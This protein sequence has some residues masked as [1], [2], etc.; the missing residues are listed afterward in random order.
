MKVRNGFVSNSSSSSFIISLEEKDKITHL[1]LDDHMMEW[2]KEAADDQKGYAY[3]DWN[4]NRVEDIKNF[5]YQKTLDEYIEKYKDQFNQFKKDSIDGYEEINKYQVLDN[6]KYN[7]DDLKW[8]IEYKIKGNQ[9]M[10]ARDYFDLYE[11][12]NYF[13]NISKFFSNRIRAQVQKMLK[14]RSKKNLYSCLFRHDFEPYTKLYRGRLFGRDNGDKNKMANRHRRYNK[15]LKENNKK[16]DKI[17]NYSNHKFVNYIVKYIIDKL[18]DNI[19]Y[20]KLKFNKK[21]DIMKLKYMVK[22]CT[23]GACHKMVKS[24]ENELQ[25]NYYQIEYSNGG[26]CGKT[27]PLAECGYFFKGIKYRRI[28]HH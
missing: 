15:H 7:E 18:F 6:Y 28:S 2:A 8:R 12:D 24:I 4:D 25:D 16:I 1:D 11:L 26:G 9:K 19:V 17:L 23:M 13:D 5:N 14:N 27:L 10:E 20:D 21:R 3:A 22:E